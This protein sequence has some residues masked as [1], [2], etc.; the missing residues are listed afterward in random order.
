[1]ELKGKNAL[2]TGGTK[3]I[4][5][6]IA[7]ALAAAG[8]NVAVASRTPAD[9]ERTAHEL[10]RSYGV[11]AEGFAADL[12]AIDA[13]ERLAQHSR[14]ALGPIDILVNNAGSGITKPAEALTEADWDRVITL[15]LKAVFFCAQA[16]GRHMI[17]E[18]RGKIINI[19]SVLGIVANKQ[20]LPYAV[21]KAG[22]LQM[23]RAL[24]LEWARYNIQVNAICPGY[25]MTEMNRAELTNTE[26]AP[27]ILRKIPMR[28]FGEVDEISKA[29]VFLAGDASNYMTGQQI[30]IDGGWCAE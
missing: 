13:I 22:V 21:A 15:D 10:Q 16:F 14:Q 8:A 18:G 12:S 5:Y 28:R 20:V 19:A 30:V 29:A 4:G 23:T 6:G 27:R 3:G 2:V 17:A 25:V 9:C 7:S 1:M 11:K 24:A 26:V